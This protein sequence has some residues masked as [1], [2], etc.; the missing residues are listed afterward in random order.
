VIV[1]GTK[2][3]RDGFL[4]CRS[5]TNLNLNKKFVVVVV[6]NKDF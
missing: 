3:K 5:V 1:A 2:K 6:V 4:K